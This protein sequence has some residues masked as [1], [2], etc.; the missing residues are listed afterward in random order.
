M[1]AMFA[2]NATRERFACA[3][4]VALIAITAC[5]R[6]PAVREFTVGSTPP[7]SDWNQ[8]FVERRIPLETADTDPPLQRIGELVIGSEGN[9]F[10]PDG[11]SKRILTFNP[12][13]KFVREI[14]GGDDGSFYF[15]LLGPIGFDPEGNLVAYDTRGAWISVLKPPAYSVLRRFQI[16]SG[17]ADFIAVDGG[18]IVTYFP[19]DKAG[20]FKR[21][22]A[23]GKRV[24]SVH[25]I[26]DERLRIFHGR[27]QT[28]GIARDSSGDL[29]GIEPSTFELVHLSPDLTVR[30]ILRAAPGDGWAPNAAAFPAGLSPYDY[31]PPH[32]KWW[33]SF[34]HIGR[35]YA[36]AHGLLLVTL[37]SS[38]GLRTNDED[39]ANI[40]HVDGRVVARGL[41]IPRGG[42]VVGAAGDRVYVVRNAHLAGA[43]SIAP[44]ELYEYRLRE[45]VA[46]ALLHN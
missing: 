4:L 28:G 11:R 5:E 45:S 34:T 9:L 30:E 27:V 16:S 14:T 29:F 39:F 12:E 2:M 43:D 22:D 33:N 40:Y 6:A 38:R 44:L 13:G 36:L 1:I 41:R 7:A 3:S 26:R 31:R 32:E 46:V 37:F 10:V 15:S 21:F 42:Q 20:V 8:L 24:A 19:S 25:P 17:V 18:A 23:S 35:P